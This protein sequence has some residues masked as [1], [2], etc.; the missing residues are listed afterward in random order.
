MSFLASMPGI[1]L[2]LNVLCIEY[3]QPFYIDYPKKGKLQKVPA[4]YVEE[5]SCGD[6]YYKNLL[7]IEIFWLN[8]FLIGSKWMNYLIRV[9]NLIDLISA[10][11]FLTLKL[12]RKSQKVD[13]IYIKS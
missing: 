8:F 13:E 11:L 7:S 10:Y 2:K 9:I 5:N 6:L 4:N 12:H 1:S 3:V